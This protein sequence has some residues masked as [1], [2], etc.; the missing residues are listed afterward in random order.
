LHR[1][2]ITDAIV[3]DIAKVE[4][5][6]ITA[7]SGG[8]LGCSVEQHWRASILR[9][10]KQNGH[11]PTLRL[12]LRFARREAFLPERDALL[13]VDTTR[14]GHDEWNSWLLRIGQED[15]ANRFPGRR[16]ERAGEIVDG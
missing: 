4:L 7:P 10:A 6:R 11:W 8:D 12:G 15:G 16:I 14:V 9:T 3:A 5:D 1:G 13:I 2:V